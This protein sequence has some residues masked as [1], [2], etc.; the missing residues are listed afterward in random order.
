MNAMN[1]GLTQ[2]RKEVREL[3]FRAVTIFLV[4]IGV[5]G[6]GEL[7]LRFEQHRRM[8]KNVYEPPNLF[9]YDAELGWALTPNWQGT[10]RQREFQVQYTIDELGFRADAQQVSGRSGKRHVFV[11]DSFTFGLGV[12]DSET[13]V[14]ILNGGGETNTYLNCA[15]PGFSTDQ[16]LLLVERDILN[17][18]PDVVDLVVYLGNDLFDNELPVPLQAARAKPYAELGPTGL[19]FK[20]IPVPLTTSSIAEARMNLAR[21]VLGDDYCRNSVRWRLENTSAVLQL[22]GE[23]VFPVRMKREELDARFARPREL[24]FAIVERTR[25]ASEDKGATLN[26]ILLPGRSFVEEPRTISAQFQDCLR[27]Q[28]VNE[29]RK[30][31]YKVIDLASALR[32]AHQESH[33]KYFFPNDG[34]LNPDGHRI[35]AQML[36]HQLR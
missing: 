12:N 7:L 6:T 27:E 18:R 36:A 13:F 29:A 11:G 10:H 25:K 32:V 4:V 31:G 30:L 33:G 28:I 35:V 3:G 2:R 24:F 22:L 23:K 5:L 19:V 1:S 16:E 8:G 14:H 15:V 20:N 34:H 9:R 17:L 21:V 26:L